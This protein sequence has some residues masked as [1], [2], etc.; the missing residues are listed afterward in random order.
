M[1]NAINRYPIVAF[2]VRYAAVH[3]LTY[4]AF[5]VVF[6]LASQYFTYFLW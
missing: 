2:T 5:G 3:T 1:K 6:M 4:L